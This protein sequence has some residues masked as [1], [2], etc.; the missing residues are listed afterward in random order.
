MKTEKTMKRILLFLL[1]AGM[2]VSLAAFAGCRKQNPASEN[3][4]ETGASTEPTTD[5]S[6]ESCDIP[7]NVQF[8]GKTFTF[9][10]YENVNANNLMLSDTEQGDI[11]ND[12]IISR[13][14]QTE[15]RFGITLKQVIYTDSL[16]QFRNPILNNMDAFSVA[17]VRCIHALTL[18]QEDLLTLPGTLPYIDTG[19]DYWNQS[20]N[21]S[22][23]VCGVNYV[24]IGDMMISIYDLTYALLFNKELQAQYQLESP[25]TLVD[26]DRWTVEAM[27]EMMQLVSGDGAPDGSKIWGY[28]AH[29]KQVLPNFWIAAGEMSVKKD[30]SDVPYLAMGTERFRNLIDRVFEITWDAD[31]FKKP[32]DETVSDVPIDI[33]ELFSSNHS[34]FMDTSFYYIQQ[35]A[36]LNADFGVIPY[37][38]MNEDQSQYYS[39]VSYYNAPVIP[40]TNPETEMTGAVLEY[41]NYISHRD[42]VPVYY[43]KI[44]KL[45]SSPDSDSYRML[46]LIFQSRVVDIGDTMLCDQIRDGFVYDMF[47]TND[48]NLSSKLA[49]AQSVLDKLLQKLP[50][51]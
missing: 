5:R 38:M 31:L 44:I 41:F 17:N 2:L 1:A 4:K 13:Q 36:G 33:I 40:V 37:P 22:I 9:A 24:Y 14:N 10:V 47:R 50:Q 26:E 18:W 48:R 32:A 19:K 25:Y 51:T 34:L 46:D 30:E 7:E 42:V 16:A 27:Y 39:R 12:S 20:I 6:E 45:Q 35:L 29:S 21:D 28:T 11:L 15:T 49:S 8:D 3:T 23:S 43:D